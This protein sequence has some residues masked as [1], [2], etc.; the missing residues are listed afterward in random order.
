MIRIAAK[1]LVILGG[2]TLVAVLLTLI[3]QESDLERQAALNRARQDSLAARVAHQ[4]IHRHNTREYARIAL[5]L[6]EKV[7]SRVALT[8]AAER[9]ELAHVRDTV[10]VREP[11]V[12]RTIKVKVD[13]AP[14]RQEDT[15]KNVEEKIKEMVE[16][17]RDDEDSLNQKQ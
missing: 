6:P 14:S 13:S 9:Q 5:Q 16:D 1:G 10:S 7:L 2:G 12:L 17:T 15:V 3:F 11:L 8:V 4:S